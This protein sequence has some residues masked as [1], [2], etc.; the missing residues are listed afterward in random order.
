MLSPNRK[1]RRK[2]DSLEA[3]AAKNKDGAFHVSRTRTL[4][5]TS[6]PAWTA[7]HFQIWGTMRPKYGCGTISIV[8]T[9]PTLFLGHSQIRYKQRPGT[10]G[11]RCYFVEQI[12]F[13]V[14]LGDLWFVNHIF[15]YYGGCKRQE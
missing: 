12:I 1:A 11:Q 9:Q 8:C 6:H 4:A 14:I 2:H 5:S 10:P 13:G 7:L 15:F 3:V